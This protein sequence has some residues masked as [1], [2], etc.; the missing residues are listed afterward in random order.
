MNRYAA[1]ALTIA[2]M[3]LVVMA[4]LVNS[5]A[6]FYMA[7]AII[8]TLGAS[9]LQAWLAVRGLRFERVTSPAVRVGELVT[10]EITVWSD[11]RLKRPLVTVFDRL[12]KQLVVADR[13]PSLPIAPSFDQPIRTRYSFR[14][15]RRGKYK[16]SQLTAFGTD[17]LG[18]VTLE[19]SYTTEPLEL[20]VYPS[21]LP[22]IADIHPT[23][24][25]GAS[26]L[27]SG[28]TH[29]VGLEPRGI[30][31]FAQGDPL[32]YIHWRSSARRGQLM[33]KEFETGSGVHIHFILQRTIG[34]EVGTQETSTFEAMCGHALF[35]AASYAKKGASVQFTSLETRD[36]ARTHPEVR[37][38]E[39]REV[40]TEIQPSQTATLAEEL[41]GLRNQFQPGDTVV[42]FI[43][44]ADNQVP[45]VISLFKEVK[46]TCLLYDAL[47]YRDPKKPG[48]T[49]ASA[50]DPM[51]IAQLESCGAETIV[52]PRVEKLG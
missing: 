4:I 2:S 6:L 7:T 38:R 14:P 17:A 32:R 36:V 21:P 23:I 29:G 18:L 51:Y 10:V 30:R 24:G 28:R 31:E 25:W 44:A 15:M 41:G 50:A 1:I 9:R 34:T 35:L 40:L 52:M 49:V 5:P 42:L 11:R 16:W 37:E 33:V 48:L 19:N 46:V 39:I 27:D 43:A 26:D 22:V 13:T 3:F 20:T 47:E 12:P 8:A 45:G